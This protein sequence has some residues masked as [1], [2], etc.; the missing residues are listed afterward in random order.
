MTSKA[1]SQTRERQLRR[2]FLVIA[3]LRASLGCTLQKLADECGVTT[4]TI[5]RD[6]EALQAVGL[7]IF[8][9]DV[10]RGFHGVRLWWFVKGSPCPVCNRGIASGKEY[11]ETRKSA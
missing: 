7:P 3:L 8:N 10:D 1:I 2:T 6:L 11:R 5:R 9:V 4:R